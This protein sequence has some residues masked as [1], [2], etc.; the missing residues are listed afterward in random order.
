MLTLQQVSSHMDFDFRKT[1]LAY[2]RAQ[3]IMLL[4]GLRAMPKGG[5]HISYAKMGFRGCKSRVKYV[6]TENRLLEASGHIDFDAEKT[7][8]Y[9]TCFWT[10]QQ[11]WAPSD[12]STENVNKYV[13]PVHVWV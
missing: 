12:F 6:K 10:L 1:R 8:P 13:Y 7:Q 4:F 2:T 11:V 5:V 9:E 3:K